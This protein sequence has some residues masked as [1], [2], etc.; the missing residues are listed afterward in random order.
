MGG[1]GYEE[2][3]KQAE[4]PT[5]PA[6][7]P[8]MAGIAR[9]LE[10]FHVARGAALGLT[11]ALMAGTVRVPQSSD[12]PVPKWA[13]PWRGEKTLLLWWN[14]TD[15]IPRR[16]DP[17]PKTLHHGNQR[18]SFYYSFCHCFAHRFCRVRS[19]P[20]RQCLG[21]CSG[22]PLFRRREEHTASH[23]VPKERGS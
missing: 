22:T 2:W 14:R 21:T 5:K 13:N 7:A 16:Y 1:A 18:K 10:G 19:R 23:D 17:C 11:W 15:Q 4:V 20:L 6:H 9:S 8:A 12:P 3:P